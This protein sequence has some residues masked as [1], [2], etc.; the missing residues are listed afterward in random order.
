[1]RHSLLSITLLLL[2]TS[3]F[4]QSAKPPRETF[5]L[6]LATSEIRVDGVLDEPAWQQATVIPVT[7]E[8]NPGDNT[9]ALVRTESLVTFDADTL[10][11]AFRAYDP[12]PSQ[13]R[14]H[15][16]DRDTP[17]LDD[18]VGWMLDTYNDRRRGYQFRVNPLGVQMDAIS[19]DVDFSEDWSFDLIWDSAGRITDEGYIVEVAIPMK[20]LRFPRADGEMT[21]GFLAMRDYPRSS[22][23]R[24]RSTYNDRDLGCFVC[25]LQSVDGLRDLSVGRNLELTPTVTA[26]RDDSRDDFPDGPLVEGEKDLDAGLTVGWGLTNMTLSATINPDFSQIEADTVQLDVNERF[27]LFFPEKRPF[28]LEGSDFFDTRLNAVFTRT[29]ADPDFG[30]KLTGKQG[31]NAFGTMVNRDRINNL[32]FPG[33]QGS[34]FASIDQEVDSA[35]VRYRRDLGE[36]STLG[37][38][39]TGRQS[40]DYSNH[41][42]GLDGSWALGDS[43]TVRYQVIGSS[44]AYPDALA[45][46]NGQ[47]L[48]TF[49]GL[50]YDLRYTH[51]SKDWF[52]SA[53]YRDLDED[54]RADHGFITRV[55]LKRASVGVNRTFR[56]EEG[57]WFRVLDVFVG[58]DRTENQDGT[59]EE[60]GGDINVSYQGPLQTEI[61][62]GLAPNREH[63]AGVDYDNF[64]RNLFFQMRPTGDVSYDIYIGAGETIDFVNARQ[65]E[66]L[67]ISPS[68]DLNIGRRFRG[69]LDYTWQEF[70]IPDG[71][72][73]LEAELARLRLFYHFNRRTFLRAILQQRSVERDQ[74]LHVV[75]VEPEV[76]QFFTQLLFSYKVNARTVLLAGYGD[77][78]LGL[79][80]ISS[81]TTGRSIFFKIGYAW[82]L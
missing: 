49:E 64:R 67:Q 36:R 51:N 37:A 46:D 20:Q 24:L 1:M 43:D 54:L 62:V 40:D 35:V 80:D 57:S 2:A 34:G 10:Y 15:Y 58:A 59:I 56:G 18:T 27:A 68:L 28:Y 29:V 14:A 55:D 25:Q 76:D 41:V 33:N 13:I 22:R 53:N 79:Q 42:Y 60:N 45:I 71:G 21:W 50:G 6:T 75:E 16:A 19:S 5:S 72:T 77:E 23:H 63:F 69:E 4:A 61:S 70:E 8:W 7:T 26:A 38:L 65:A 47:P 48:G 52:W 39:Y 44:T 9:P 66:F 12:D 3:L 73:F 74:N 11:I 82:I 32:I 31:S 78:S 81:T 17:F 30:L